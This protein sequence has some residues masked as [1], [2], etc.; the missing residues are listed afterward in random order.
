MSN[1]G[2]VQKAEEDL[3]YMFIAGA[4][5]FFRD[6]EIGNKQPLEIKTLNGDRFFL[7]LPSVLYSSGNLEKIKINKEDFLQ[8]IKESFLEAYNIYNQIYSSDR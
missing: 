5:E 4:E 3:H 2:L 6:L 7:E 1:I 8:R